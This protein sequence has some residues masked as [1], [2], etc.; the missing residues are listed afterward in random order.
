LLLHAKDLFVRR[1]HLGWPASHPLVAL[2]RSW[3]LFD[4]ARDVFIAAMVAR[5]Q[6]TVGQKEALTQ[7]FTLPRWEKVLVLCFFQITFRLMSLSRS[8]AG[9]RSC[10]YVPKICSSPPSADDV[11]VVLQL[12]RKARLE[13]DIRRKGGQSRAS[14]YARAK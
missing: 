14:D 1:C 13:R 5:R 3:D 2:I 10:L 9:I 8:D 6:E 11:H 4:Q 12:D 7:P